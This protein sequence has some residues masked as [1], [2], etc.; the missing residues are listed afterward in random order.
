VAALVSSGAT[1]GTW[2]AAFRAIASSAEHAGPVAVVLDE[3][4]YIAATDPSFEAQLQAIWDRVVEPA[5]ILLIVIGSDLAMMEGLTSYDRPLYGR[6][7]RQLVIEPLHTGEV[8][9]LLGVDGADAVDAA[10]VVG[11]F[12]LLVLSWPHGMPLE[13][14]VGGCCSTTAEAAGPATAGLR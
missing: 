14:F 6:P 13:D 3:L 9:H 12:P 5:P 10:L 7:T 11:G 8:A 2:D 4:P 1:F